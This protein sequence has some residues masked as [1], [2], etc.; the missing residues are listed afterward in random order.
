MC[1]RGENETSATENDC[2]A[3]NF[4]EREILARYPGQI[5]KRA[6]RSSFD[7]VHCIYIKVG[8][9]MDLQQNN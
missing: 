9:G 3:E 2:G 6:E 1:D 4:G 8:M 7:F 5:Q